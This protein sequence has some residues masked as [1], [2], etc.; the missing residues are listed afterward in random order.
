MGKYNLKEGYNRIRFY[1]SHFSVLQD[2]VH[3]S[4]SVPHREFQE[5]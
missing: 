1:I 5:F 4:Q 3:L 2:F